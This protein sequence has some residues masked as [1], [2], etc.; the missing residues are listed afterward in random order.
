MPTKRATAPEPVDVDEVIDEVVPEPKK[1]RES[2]E[3]SVQPTDTWA[4]IA[5][6]YDISVQDLLAANNANVHSYLYAGQIV[7]VP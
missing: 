2:Y 1:A 4:K 5:A 6:N 7:T 3:V